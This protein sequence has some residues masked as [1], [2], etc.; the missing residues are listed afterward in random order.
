MRNLP[1]PDLT[2]PEAVA[3]RTSKGVGVTGMVTGTGTGTGTGMVW[4]G[5]GE[6][7]ADL[8]LPW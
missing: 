4:P 8:L 2:G 5:V 3:A 7:L 6:G 1:S